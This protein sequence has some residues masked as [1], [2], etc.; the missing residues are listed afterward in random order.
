MCQ[1]NHDAETKQSCKGAC[2]GSRRNQTETELHIQRNECHGES[3][4]E[5][6][7]SGPP[8]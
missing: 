7:V 8:T 3:V 5:K 1:G 6:Q 4:D 2:A